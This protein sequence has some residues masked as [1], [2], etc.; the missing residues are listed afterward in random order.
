MQIIPV[1]GELY[2]ADGR[3]GEHRQTDMHDEVNSLFS[4]F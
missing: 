1:E 4:Q 3:T 2:I